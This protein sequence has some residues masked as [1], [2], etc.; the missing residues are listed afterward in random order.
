MSV[1]LYNA[2]RMPTMSMSKF[3]HWLN[4]LRRDLQV[5]ADRAIRSEIVRRTVRNKDLKIAFPNNKQI[6]T[7]PSSLTSNWIEFMGEYRTSREMKLRNPL[8]YVEC[9]IIFHFKGNF[10]YFLALTDQSAYTDLI[11]ALPNI[12]EYGY[13]DNTDKPDAISARA[14]KQRQRIWESIFGNTQFMLGGLVFMLIG[15]YNIAMPKQGT[16]EEFIPDF[17]TRLNE[18]AKELA[19]NE[20]MS[21]TTETVDVSNSFDHYM[22]L[23]SLEGLAAREVAKNLIKD[24]LKPELT[25]D[26]LV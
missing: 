15:E 8:V 5:I 22:W 14:W 9:E 26:D 2:W 6:Q 13:W 19:W 24:L 11:S 18:V 12:E 3:Q 25:Y 20:Y 21:K 17:N 16:V 4:Q 23:K 10:I 7:A 1:K